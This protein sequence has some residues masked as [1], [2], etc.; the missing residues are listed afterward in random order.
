MPCA[1]ACETAVLHTRT[2][3]E[4]QRFFFRLMRSCLRAIMQWAVHNADQPGLPE[5]LIEVLNFFHGVVRC[6]LF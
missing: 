4:T 5:F 6:H 1:A 2:G 3:G